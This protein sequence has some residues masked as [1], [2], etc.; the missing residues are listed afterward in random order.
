MY[1]DHAMVVSFFFLLSAQV[2][3]DHIFMHVEVQPPCIA[4][5]STKCSRFYAF[6]HFDVH[7]LYWLVARYGGID[8]LGLFF[9]L[10]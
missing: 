8:C 10:G 4:F 9:T 7:L 2:H 1:L 6:Q 3:T 5:F